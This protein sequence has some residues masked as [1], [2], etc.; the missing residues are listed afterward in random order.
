MTFYFVVAAHLQRATV[1]LLLLRRVLPSRRP[2]PG[3][4]VTPTGVA[5]GCRLPAEASNGSR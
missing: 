5:L 1:G 3:V 4:L 2:R